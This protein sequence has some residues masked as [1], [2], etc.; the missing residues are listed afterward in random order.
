[1]SAGSS[2]NGSARSSHSCASALGNRAARAGSSS[3]VIAERRARDEIARLRLLLDPERRA[4]ACRARAPSPRRSGRAP[5]RA[6]PRSRARGSRR[7]ARSRSRRPRAAS[8]RGAPSAAR[9]T[10]GRRT[11]RAAA[12]GPR[13]ASSTSSTTRPR[14][15]R[16]P[17]GAAPDAPS[18]IGSP[19]LRD[20]RVAEPERRARGLEERAS[21]SATVER[22]QISSNECALRELVGEGEQRL[23]ALGLAALLL[24][25]ARVLERD[26]R[27]ARE[28]LEQPDVVLVELV[29]AELRDHDRAGDARAVAQRHDG[30]RLLELVGAGNPEREL[31]LERVRDEQRL[32]GL[33]RAAR[34][35][36]ADLR[37]VYASRGVADVV[38]VVADERDRHAAR[39]R[40]AGRRGSCGS[41]SAA[42][43]RSRS[44]CRSARTSFSRLS[45]PGERLQH[46]QVRDRAHVAAARPRPALGR[47]VA[48]SS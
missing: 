38:V 19:T 7:A 25:E 5:L 29:D 15:R 31:A 13:R 37:C 47:S 45:L 6:T 21:P 9:P 34:D 30:E 44:C 10:P 27:L 2:T 3:R 39:R 36:L 14:R 4:R 28:H 46:L 20:A 16:R 35:A 12:R 17:P 11:P 18:A 33:D 42:A 41:R 8:S 22:L 23:R 40:R 26:R 24:V 43:A 32:A 48:P 1:M